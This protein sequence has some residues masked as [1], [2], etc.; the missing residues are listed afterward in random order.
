MGGYTLS[1]ERKEKKARVG[2]VVAEGRSRDPSRNV[3]VIVTL[4]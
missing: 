1:L 2:E 4:M 3:R